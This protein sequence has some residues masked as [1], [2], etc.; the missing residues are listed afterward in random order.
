MVQAID[1]Y[2]TDDDAVK[3]PDSGNAEPEPPAEEKNVCYGV[4]GDYWVY[5]TTLLWRTQE[6]FVARLNR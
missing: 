4:G 3:S 1:S 5:L 2:I 6:T